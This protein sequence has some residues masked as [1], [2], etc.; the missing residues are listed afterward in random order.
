MNAEAG[1]PRPPILTTPRLTAGLIVALLAAPL[2]LL[3]LAEGGDGWALLAYLALVLATIAVLRGVRREPGS[4]LGRRAVRRALVVAIGAVCA[5]L[6]AGV[7]PSSAAAV[8]AFLL[9]ALVLLNFTLGVATERIATA[10][11]QS[12][13]ERQEALRNRSHR[14]AYWTFAILVGGTLLVADVASGRSR[15]WLETTMSQGGGIV[16]LELMLVLPAITMAWLEPDRIA[17]EH[18]ASTSSPRTRIGLAMLAI[19]IVTP[20]AF[21]LALTVLPAQTTSSVRSS[22]GPAGAQCAE[23]TAATRVGMVVSATIPIHA[24]AC[25]DGRT[26]TEE[27]GLNASDCNPDGGAMTTIETARCARTTAPDGTLRYTYSAVARAQ[28]LPCVSREV[29]MQLVLDRDGHVVRFP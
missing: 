13:D 27:W 12:V 11:D 15:S 1:R 29:T 19:T 4:W 16:L 25:W 23:F 18:A 28:F 17:P 26:A 2:L 21:A 24:V 6:L 10:P 20:F 7:S 9:I 8:Q 5:G 22:G 3:A 14:L